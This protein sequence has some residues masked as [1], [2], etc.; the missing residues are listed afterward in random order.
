MN[1]HDLERA[2]VV[3]RGSCFRAYTLCDLLYNSLCIRLALQSRREELMDLRE[4]QPADLF[5]TFL[6]LSVELE[7]HFMIKVGVNFVEGNDTGEKCTLAS[8]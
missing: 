7:L 4:T 1:Y 6:L 3:Q 8:Y 2:T 5:N